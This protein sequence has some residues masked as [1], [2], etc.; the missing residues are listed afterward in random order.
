VLVGFTE[1]YT[2]AYMHG[3][4]MQGGASVIAA[5]YIPLL[6]LDVF[7]FALKVYLLATSPAYMNRDKFLLR[8]MKEYALIQALCA[9]FS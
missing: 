8:F 5:L 7:L 4:S 3:G 2:Y 9:T 6:V 1:S